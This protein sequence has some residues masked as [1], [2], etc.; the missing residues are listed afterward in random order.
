[1]D[2]NQTANISKFLD[3]KEIDLKIKKGSLVCV[4]G[5]VG[6]GKSSL[7][8]AISGEMI[9]VSNESVKELNEG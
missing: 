6:S 3:L 5:G 2:L 1:M 4:I 7:L 8:N 9:F